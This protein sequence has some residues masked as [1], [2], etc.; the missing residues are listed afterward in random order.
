MQWTKN[1]SETVTKCI[2]FAVAAAPGMALTALAYVLPVLTAGF[3]YH[4]ELYNRL[5]KKGEN[6][7]S[8]FPSAA[9]LRNTISDQAAED[10]VVLSHELEDKYVFIGCDKGK[11]TGP[12]VVVTLLYVHELTNCTLYVS[13]EQE[14]D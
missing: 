1:A 14:R 4:Y 5:A 12:Y 6:F 2:A 7:T 9:T 3:L 10:M 13:R 11:C 8:C